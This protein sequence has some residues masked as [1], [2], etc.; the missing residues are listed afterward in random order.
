MKDNEIQKAK[1]Y[2]ILAIVNKL[3][4]EKSSN[5]GYYP[6]YREERTASL[7]INKEENFWRD[8]GCDKGG[9]TIQLVMECLSLSFQEA[10]N[11]I[12][13]SENIQYTSTISKRKS[14]KIPE[15]PIKDKE[16]YEMLYQNREN[17]DKFFNYLFGRGFSKEM[18]EKKK[19]FKVNPGVYK[20]LL[21]KFSHEEINNAGLLSKNGNWLFSFH[22]L[23]I[24][25]L[26]SDNRIE[27]M[28]GRAVGS[29]EEK[30]QM[31]YLALRKKHT[32]LYNLYS[33][34][35]LQD[36]DELYICEGEFDAITMNM[37][38][39]YSIAI[40]GVGNVKLLKK[41]KW[42]HKNNIL[43]FDG[44]KAGIKAMNQIVHHIPAKI[45]RLPDG[46]DVNQIFIERNKDNA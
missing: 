21:K 25:Y 7:R 41:I 23:I 13:S 30:T 2:P 12:N 33:L 37:L 22:R 27:Y 24:P 26:D 28:R 31:K 14:E 34:K 35:G 16:I 4:L 32:R 6:P 43:I 39:K 9:D 8:F 3:N 36:K 11:W 17:D 18:I 45:F 46:K 40:P 19:L 15:D 1:N 20:T 10:L 38:D 42:Q 29:L 44:D 5:G